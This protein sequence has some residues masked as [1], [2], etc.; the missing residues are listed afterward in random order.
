MK[1]LLS[2]T[3]GPCK[4]G[5]GGGRGGGGQR[6]GLLQVYSRRRRQSVSHSISGPRGQ[7]GAGEGGRER[8]GAICAFDAFC[9]LVVPLAAVDARRTKTNSYFDQ[10]DMDRAAGEL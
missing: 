10:I 3:I 5:G 8:E 4:R 2:V 9:V 6:G 1:H 7:R